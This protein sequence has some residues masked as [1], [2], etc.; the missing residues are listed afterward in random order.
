MLRGIQKASKNW[1]G[2]VVMGLVMSL[3]V[4]S[5]AIWGIGDIFRGFGRSTVAKVGGTEITIEA[6]R[7]IWNDRLQQIG[8]QIGRPITG[9][10]ARSLGLDRQILAQVVQETVLDEQ[11]RRMRLALPDEEVSKRITADPTFRGLTGQFDR[12]RFQ[13]IIRNAGYTEQRFVQEQRRQLLRQQIIGSVVAGLD[14]PDAMADALNRYEN[15]QRTV[16]YVSLG[17]AQ[18]GEIPEPPP[19]VLAQYF[20]ERKTL[21]RAPEYRKLVLMTLTP[22]EI[23]P[24][25]EV[26]DADARKAYEERKSRYETPERRQ[27][28]QI[29]FPNPE[30]AKAAAERIA[31]GASFADIAAERGLKAAD[32]DIGLVPKSGIIDQAIADAAFALPSGGTSE[33]VQGRFGTVLVHVTKVEPGHARSVEEVLPELK[34]DLQ[35]ERARTE[36]NTKHDKIEDERLAGGTLAEVAQ[37]AG[38]QIRTVEAVDRSG[39]APDGSVVPLPQGVDLLTPAFNAELGTENEELQLQG[40][41]YLWFE[42]T[43]VTASRER[44]L[45]EVKDRV[46]ER[47]RDEEIAKRLRETSA[48]IVEKAKAGTP[49]GEAAAGVPVQT[50]EVKRG[51][52]S[53]AL[54]AKVIDEIFR[55]AKD[56]VGAAEGDSATQRIVFRVTAISDPK[57]EAGSDDAKR[58]SENLTRSLSEDIV[59]QYVARL[60]RD[61][62]TSIN[63]S[64]LNQ[65]VG[66][67]TQ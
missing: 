11:A 2:K 26:S 5:F 15:E 17:R 30:E 38:M 52:R 20:E 58:I 49:L 44:T 37:R 24:W 19:E 33:P 66:G 29:V 3:L 23:A 42:V 36:M 4:V 67:T 60:E 46:V 61:I 31:K 8:R 48:A 40:G 63:P 65:V 53:D 51:T 41:G 16:E 35:L 47:W 55:T 43:D 32:I 56:Q 62:G 22:A 25:I 64:A 28:Q 6:F 1:L 10:Q 54:G 9:D 59:L 39:R 27:V 14:A 50:A 45:D 7:Q 34:R 18:A 13:Q 57:I 21:F 12:A